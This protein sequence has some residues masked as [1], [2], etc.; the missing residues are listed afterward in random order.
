M[1][2]DV[3]R[4]HA[5][6]RDGEAWSTTPEPATES[7]SHGDVAV[8]TSNAELGLELIDLIRSACL[9]AESG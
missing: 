8:R 4:Y 2:I 3:T 1:F 6:G 7:S 5:L 9:G